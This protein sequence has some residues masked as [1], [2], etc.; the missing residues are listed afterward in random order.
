MLEAI[1]VI[2]TGFA[3]AGII[4]LVFFITFIVNISLEN[5]RNRNMKLPV[6]LSAELFEDMILGLNQSK[7]DYI[8]KQDKVPE[9]VEE[10]LGQALAIAN[11]Q[12]ET[13]IDALIRVLSDP[14]KRIVFNI[15][16][17]IEDNKVNLKDTDEV[18][19]IIGAVMDLVKEY[20]EVKVELSNLS[21]EEYQIIFA[22]I[23][24]QIYEVKK[25]V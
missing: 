20:P 3:I 18:F 23:T 1:N 8:R 15:L 12:K 4:M 25:N 13:D 10:T 21:K 11:K 22:V 2:S 7:S 5:M 17:I 14:A 6:I 19:S 16:D 24:E 9:I